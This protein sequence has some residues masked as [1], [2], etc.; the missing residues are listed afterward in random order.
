MKRRGVEQFGAVAVAEVL[1]QPIAPR[2]TR[3]SQL[4]DAQL[5]AAALGGSLK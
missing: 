5:L 1:A 4:T 3:V 2:D